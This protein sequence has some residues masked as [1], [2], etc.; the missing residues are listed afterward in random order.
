[1][2]VNLDIG[3]G[4]KIPIF[5]SVGPEGGCLSSCLKIHP[6]ELFSLLTVLTLFQPLGYFKEVDGLQFLTTGPFHLHWN[7]TLTRC[8]SMGPSTFRHTLAACFLMGS[9][10]VA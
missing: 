7:V 6:T 10:G 1:M 8:H 5:L 4:F 3:L 9:H 2:S